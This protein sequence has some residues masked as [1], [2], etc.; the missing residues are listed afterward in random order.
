MNNV[1]TPA[2]AIARILFLAVFVAC[3]VR[4]AE[5]PP[6][7]AGLNYS[8]DQSALESLDREIDATGTDAAKLAALETRL[9]TLLRRTDLTFAARQAICQR[10]GLVLAQGTAKTKADAFKPLGAM[11][12]D[13]RDSDL[14]RLALEPVSGAVV[15]GL[16]VAALGKTS[17]RT[18]LALIDSIARRRIAAAVPALT[19]FLRDK[20]T[21]TA[22]AAARGLGAIADPA[23]LASLEAIPEPNSDAVVNAKLLAASRIAPATALPLL[24]DLQRN[25]KSPAHRAAAFR[26]SL[27]LDPP[28]AAKKISEVLGGSDW[29]FKQV[30]LES[31]YASPAPGL[32]AALVAKLGTWDAPTQTSVI[33]ALARRGEVTVT[34]AIIAA[35]THQEAEVRAAAVTALG[36]L[37]GTAETVALLAKVAAGDSSESKAAR[38]SLARLDGPGVSAA[39][40]AGAERGDAAT[41]PVY[42]EQL[43]LR[44]MTEGLPVLLKL[45]NESDA[46]LRAAAVGALGELAPASE[47]KAV[48][49]WAIGAADSNEQSRA[50]RAAV[51]IILRNPSVASRGVPL[52]QAIESADAE[53]T[54]RLLPAL[55]RIGGSASAETAAR[56]AL[57]DDVKVADAAT[58]ALVR[59]NDATAVASLVTIAEKAKQPATRSAAVKGAI[60]YFERNREPWTKNNTALVA[61]LLAATQDTGPRKQ[62]LALLNRANDKPALA[63]A[64]GLQSDAALGGAARETAEIIRSNLAGAPKVRAS[65]AESQVRNMIDGKTSTRWSVATEGDEWV[66]IEFKQSRPLHRL[67][68]DQT[69]RTNEFPERYEVFVTDDPKSPGP[70]VAKGT[71]QRNKTVIDFPAETHGRFVIVKNVAERADIPWAICELFVD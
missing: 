47:L 27:E 44:G 39:I 13:D 68:L 17:G 16:F 9:L 57:R 67:T 55:G 43:A 21:A 61:R 50:L 62:L 8:G 11:L 66:E 5:A 7:L 6:A 71:G 23:A 33:T 46:T 38:Q 3:V 10:L 37:P 31:I 42:I 34:P 51:N 48:L 32:V 63:L 12:A 28:A 56:L 65:G 35:V 30:A 15:D 19:K 52:Y 14:A 41:R 20:D 29:T 22:D 45:R 1:N 40:L 2:V 58:A 49:N 59:W 53:A 64:E 26:L 70:A 60:T 24:Q 4:A 54:L 25:A 18:R 69:G 36:I